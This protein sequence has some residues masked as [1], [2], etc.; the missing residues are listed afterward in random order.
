MKIANPQNDEVS[1]ERGSVRAECKSMDP[2]RIA[3]L[4]KENL[5][6]QGLVAE[7]LIKNQ[8]LRVAPV[9]D[10]EAGEPRLSAPGRAG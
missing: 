1:L 10:M 3:E 7:L 4:E 2:H 8:K 5:R 9:N 6:L